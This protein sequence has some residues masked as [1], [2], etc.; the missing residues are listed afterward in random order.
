MQERGCRCKATQSATPNMRHTKVQGTLYCVQPTQTVITLHDTVIT[1]C[2]QPLQISHGAGAP[3]AYPWHQP[4]PKSDHSQWTSGAQLPAG[5]VLGCHISKATGMLCPSLPSQPP[6]PCPA[7]LKH[8][9]CS[10]NPAAQTSHHTHTDPQTQQCC[11]VCS[12]RRS[13]AGSSSGKMAHTQKLC[14]PTQAH[15]HTHTPYS[16]QIRYRWLTKASILLRHTW[17]LLPKQAKGFCILALPHG[18]AVQQAAA[19]P[20]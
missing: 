7:E 10:P 16:C 17:T 18:V 1:P 9:L 3:A 15:I 13:N 8:M 6:Y 11:G 2:Q 4:A 19:H 20:R 5:M 14:D 12:T